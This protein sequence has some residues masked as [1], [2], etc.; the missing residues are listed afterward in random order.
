MPGSEMAL[1][2]ETPTQGKARAVL[3]ETAARGRDMTLEA[4]TPTQSK[5][6]AVLAEAA[7]E[8]C[9]W[10]FPLSVLILSVQAVELISSASWIF[11][12]Q[13][14]K[15]IWSQKKS[16]CRRSNDQPPQL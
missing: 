5:T 1:E 7:A 4:E 14:H 10:P 8:F 12:A 15:L 11:F 13:V 2:A 3:A 16:S 6:K 9:V